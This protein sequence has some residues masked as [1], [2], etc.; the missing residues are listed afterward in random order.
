MENMQ[1]EDLLLAQK[2][3]KGNVQAYGELIK[4]HKEYLYRTAFSYV[5]IRIWHWMFFR[6]PPFRGCYLYII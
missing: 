2:A 4:F 6:K 5:K 3:K 1:E